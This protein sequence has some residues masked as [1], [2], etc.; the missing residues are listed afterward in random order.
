MLERFWFSCGHCRGEET[1][2][3]AAEMR[4]ATAP[5]R[6]GIG[7]LPIPLTAMTV[8]LLPLLCGIVSGLLGSRLLADGTSASIGRWQTAGMLLGL[9]A[10]AG[11]A[12][13][14]LQ[15]MY[16]L[17]TRLRRETQ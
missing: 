16:R 10:G 8:F 15:A 17:W 1:C 11:L 6:A 3:F 13:L 5:P 2:P 9:V 4:D 12:K 7:R 14:L